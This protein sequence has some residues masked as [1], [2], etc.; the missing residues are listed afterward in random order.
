MAKRIILASSFPVCLILIGIAL[1]LAGVGRGQPQGTP[2]PLDQAKQNVISLMKTADYSAAEAALDALVESYSGQSILLDALASIAREANMPYALYYIGQ[3]HR[4]QGRCKDARSAFQMILDRYPQSAS[5]EKAM[6]G[7]KAISVLE[8]MA[9]ADYPGALM[10]IRD[11]A[12]QHIGHPD[13][14]STVL[15]SGKNFAWRRQYDSAIE[16]YRLVIENYPTSPY[17]QEAHNEMEAATRAKQILSA[18]HQQEDTTAEV[19]EFIND[20]SGYP[21]L[22]NMLYYVAEEYKMAEQYAR[23]REVYGTIEAMFPDSDIAKLVRPRLMEINILAAISKDPNALIELES[24]LSE[25]DAAIQIESPADDSNE[26]NSLIQR[27]VEQFIVEFCKDNGLP[28][29]VCEIGDIPDA[30]NRDRQGML[31]CELAERMYDIAN[32]YKRIGR[33]IDGQA[34][35]ERAATLFESVAVDANCSLAASWSCYY[36]GNCNHCLSRF[37]KALEYYWRVLENWPDYQWNWSAQYLIGDCLEQLKKAGVVEASQA[38]E[39]IEAAY[40]AVAEDYPDFGL[41]DD[42]LTRL[43][44]MQDDMQQWD[45]AIVYWTKVR[46]YY[47][48]QNE[49][50]P[51]YYGNSIRRLG[52]DYEQIKDMDSAIGLYCRFIRQYPDDPYA[53]VIVNRLAELLLGGSTGC[54]Y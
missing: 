21:Y 49:T 50:P 1:I 42:A 3:E 5:A 51:G 22:S 37:D 33:P 13:T 32:R 45:K 16:V 23:A 9:K 2:S 36:A 25:T 44:E 38:N 40:L 31:V 10:L 46:E 18:I 14:P 52:G 34:L 43:A 17:A 48:R 54:K 15:L 39:E 4:W 41:V 20:L 11:L 53:E 19:N 35:M 26:P 7:I 24:L 29:D 8:D 12:Q 28:A 47:E 30:G 6:M 27:A